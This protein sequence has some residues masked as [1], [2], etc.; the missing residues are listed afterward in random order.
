M[1]LAGLLAPIITQILI[2][3]IAAVIRAH[4]NATGNMPTDAQVI[5]ALN[6]D[7]DR[8]IALGQAWL[9]THPATTSAAPVAAK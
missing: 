8:Y 9:D 6:A 4:H 1:P 2:P 3:E 5:A 7:A